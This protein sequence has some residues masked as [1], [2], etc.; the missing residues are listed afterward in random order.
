M[1]GVQDAL[2]PEQSGLQQ[3]NKPNHPDY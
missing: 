1:W 2:R 3:K